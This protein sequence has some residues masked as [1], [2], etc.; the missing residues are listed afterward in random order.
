[1]RVGG[2]W[3]IL[4]GFTAEFGEDAEGIRTRSARNGRW[5]PASAARGRGKVECPRS[6]PDLGPISDSVRC[7]ERRSAGIRP[8]PQPAE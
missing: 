6:R 1:V 5:W 7:L 3:R 2:D 4:V 8:S